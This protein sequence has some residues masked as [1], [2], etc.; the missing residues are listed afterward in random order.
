MLASEVFARAVVV[1]AV[2]RPFPDMATSPKRF[3]LLGRQSGTCETG[4]KLCAD[5]CILATEVSCG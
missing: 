1:A 3:G 4:E 2:A 5:F